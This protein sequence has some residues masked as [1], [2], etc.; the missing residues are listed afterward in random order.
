M[1]LAEEALCPLM[2]QVPPGFP[3]SGCFMGGTQ[4]EIQIGVKSPF[5]LKVAAQLEIEMG[6]KS[7]LAT[8]PNVSYIF[9]K[10]MSNGMQWWVFYGF[11]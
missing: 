9:G 5:L 7:P 3:L 8:R 6:V 11:V 10:L 4:L 1:H 2:A